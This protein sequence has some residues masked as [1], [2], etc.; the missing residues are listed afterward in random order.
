MAWLWGLCGVLAAGPLAEAQQRQVTRPA[1]PGTEPFLAN[2]TPPA[3]APGK[4]AE[5][6]VSGRNLKKVER[7]LISGN[8]IEVV[9]FRPKSETAATVV[10]RAEEKAEPGY[11]EVR[12][13]GPHGLSNLALIRVDRLNPVDETEPNDD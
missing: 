7:L 6:T 3:V 13:T 5:W 1:N 9:A 11:R 2:I 10:V 4:T 8:G 12:A